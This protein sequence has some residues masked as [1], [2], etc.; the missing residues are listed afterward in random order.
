[1]S[2]IGIRLPRAG[3]CSFYI[4]VTGR[5]M[6]GLIFIY[7]SLFKEVKIMNL[8]YR[9]GYL[10]TILWIILIVYGFINF[11]SDNESNKIFIVLFFVFA[12]L[13]LFPIYFITVYLYYRIIKKTS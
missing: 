9:V 6:V 8:P 10:L 4:E 2:K 5:I 11:D 13:I 1:M 7:T 12:G 3:C